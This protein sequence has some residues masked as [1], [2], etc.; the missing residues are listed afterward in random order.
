MISFGVGM[1]FAMLAAG[2]DG[3]NSSLSTLA[4][5]SL[6]SIAFMIRGIYVMN[7]N[8]QLT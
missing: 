5:L 2:A 3:P 6:V 1:L 7:R 8:G 4:L